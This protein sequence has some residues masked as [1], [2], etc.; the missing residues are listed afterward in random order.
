MSAIKVVIHSLPLLFQ[1]AMTTFVL[2]L[3]ATAIGLVIAALV[4]AL[5]LS[6]RRWLARAGAVYVSFFR[7]VPLLVQL[8]LIYYFLPFVGIDVP[9]LVA[10]VVGLSLCTAAYLAE[11]LRGGLASISPGQREAGEMLG[12]AKSQIWRRLLLPQAVRSMLPAIVSEVTLLLKASSL[13]S[14]IGVAEL[15]RT[16]QNVAAS[17]YRPLEIYATV[18]AIYLALNLLLAAGGGMMERRFGLARR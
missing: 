18:G 17:T 1:A 5:R 14:V 6:K 10:A 9:S 16:G 13:I 8:L 7:G 4:C 3:V 15:T 2:S 12:L 11:I